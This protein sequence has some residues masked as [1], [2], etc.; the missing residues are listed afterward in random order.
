M[1]NFENVCVN[2]IME[3]KAS[4]KVLLNLKTSHKGIGY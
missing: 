4:A 1:N 3:A 2:V